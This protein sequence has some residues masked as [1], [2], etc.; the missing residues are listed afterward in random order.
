M[1]TEVLAIA[2]SVTYRKHEKAK[3]PGSIPVSATKSPTHN[4]NFQP[5]VVA[6]AKSVGLA[7]GGYPS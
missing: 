7:R 3:S 2:V 5:I 4:L 1:N 6:V